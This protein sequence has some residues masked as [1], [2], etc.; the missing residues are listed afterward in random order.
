MCQRRAVAITQTY[1]CIFAAT[2]G[3]SVDEQ[4]NFTPNSYANC[5]GA[6]QHTSA[7]LQKIVNAFANTTL[8][9]ASH[10]MRH[11]AAAIPCT[12]QFIGGPF[13]FLCAVVHYI[14]TSVRK[15]V[16]SIAIIALSGCVWYSNRDYMSNP[17]MA[18]TSAVDA[19]VKVVSFTSKSIRWATRAC[20]RIA[21]W[22]VAL[23]E[24]LEH[25]ASDEE[26][27]L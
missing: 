24:K 1:T 20:L 5:P 10:P 15:Q 6:Q 8:Q 22:L 2:F 18:N 11:V 27:T 16:T 25:G 4:N 12:S 9:Y 23:H 17:S 19:E 21:R 14:L 26:T 13:R 3:P 7:T